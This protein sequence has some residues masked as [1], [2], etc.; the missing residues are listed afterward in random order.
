MTR[1]TIARAVQIIA[2]GLIAVVALT[3]LAVSL[4]SPLVVGGVIVLA[5]GA[6]AVAWASHHAKWDE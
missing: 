6:W 2:F 5:L 3:I 4:R 1:R